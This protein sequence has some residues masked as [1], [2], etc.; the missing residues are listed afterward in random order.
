M[1]VSKPCIG[2]LVERTEQGRSESPLFSLSDLVVTA[3]YDISMCLKLWGDTLPCD[4]NIREVTIDDRY[5][6]A[7]LIY[8]IMLIECIVLSIG[9]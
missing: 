7:P 1:G 4:L 8:D 6:S 9:A 5:L 2:S 3:R